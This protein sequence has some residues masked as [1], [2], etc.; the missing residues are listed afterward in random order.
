MEHENIMKLSVLYVTLLRPH[1]EYCIQFRAPHFRKDADNERIQR[2]TY[3]NSGTCPEEGK[4]DDW[5][6]G[7]K[8]LWRETERTG[9]V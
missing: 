4:E 1:L 8:A 2:N 5:G 6:S 7:N 9:H 3:G